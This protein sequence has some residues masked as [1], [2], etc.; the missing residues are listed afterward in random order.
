MCE[1]ER[2]KIQDTENSRY[3]RGYVSSPKLFP[4]HSVKFIRQNLQ[5]RDFPGGPVAKTLRS[6]SKR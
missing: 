4:V 5:H 2:E 6:Q 1:R 3:R